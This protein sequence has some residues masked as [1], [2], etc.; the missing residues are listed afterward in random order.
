MTLWRWKALDEQGKSIKGIWEE[1]SKE[2][3]VARLRKQKL[4]P[5]SI[6]KDFLWSFLIRLSALDR[7]IYWSRAAHKIGSM[8]EAGIPLLT[9]LEIMADKERDRYRKR[10]WNLV[11]QDVREG[12]EL[13]SSLQSFNPS[14]GP[15]LVAL[16]TIGE[17]SGTLTRS[18]LEISAQLEEEH[19]FGQKIKTALFYPSLLLVIAVAI[20]YF[21]SAFV[22]P[23]Y[24]DLFDSLGAELPFIT[25]LVFSIG[26]YI[27]YILVV[28]ISI[29]STLIFYNI[30]YHYNNNRNRNYLSIL[31]GIGRIK[32]YQD[33]ILFCSLMQRLLDAGISL[34]QSLNLLDEAVKGKEIKKLINNL[35]FEVNEGRRLA[36]VF[37]LSIFPA[38]AVR[39]VGVGEESGRLS[40]MLGYMARIFRTE[41]EQKLQ[42]WMNLLQPLLII[43]IAGIIGVVAVGVLIPIFEM[44][45]HIR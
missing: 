41:L 44:S 9:V 25:S 30:R 19:N 5:I 34:P 27:P 43:W 45:M 42:S 40:E 4:F 38:E 36:P 8:L 11:L 24:V 14:L 22:L 12:N 33:I 15:H 23:M 31:P 21:L 16:V 20:I 32:K 17:R 18:L 28:F 6:H 3:V 29:I 39:M 1:N 2:S 13:S 10:A 26:T 37:A 7:K 35:K